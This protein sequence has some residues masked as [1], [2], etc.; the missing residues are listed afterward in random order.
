MQ[1]R[2]GQCSLRQQELQDTFRYCTRQ[3]QCA[4]LKADYQQ[5]S[6]ATSLLT[7]FNKS[8]TISLVGRRCADDGGWACVDDASGGEGSDDGCKAHLGWSLWEMKK[9]VFGLLVR[10]GC[11]VPVAVDC[12]EKLHSFNADTTPLY[13]FRPQVVT[14]TFKQ[15]PLLSLEFVRSYSLDESV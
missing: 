11:A 9:V 14:N 7:S 1:R 5:L 8:L 4:G 6:V 10:W 13:T 3:P 2:R 12:D 15:D